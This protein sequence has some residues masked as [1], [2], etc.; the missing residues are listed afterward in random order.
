M[1]KIIHYL[2]QSIRP[3]VAL[4]VL[5]ILLV[6]GN[7][8]AQDTASLSPAF[9]NIAKPQSTKGWIY[10]WENYKA[11]PLTLFDDL[12][13]AFELSKEDKMA[14][15]K[16]VK[17]EIGFTHYR[18]QQYYKSIPVLFGEYMVH[19]QSDGFVNTANGRLITG[20]TLGNMATI[21]EKQALA[22]AL[23]FMGAHKYLWQNPEMENDLKRQKKSE[24][25]SYFP[26]GELVFAPNN[27]NETYNAADYRLC[28]H[29][30]IYTDGGDVKPKSVY[31]DVLTGKVIYYTDL[32]MECSSATGTSAFNGSVSF[33]TEFSGSTYRSHDNCQ[34]TDFYVYNCNRGG[35]T[36][37]F[38]T[39]ADNSW[40]NQ[41][42]VQAQWGVNR[43][44]NYY[45][46]VHS[47]TSWDNSA[48]D[49]IAYNN[50]VYGSPPTANNAC[51]G[52]TGNSAIFGAGTTTAATDDW[53]TDDLIGHEFTHGVTQSSANLVYNKESGA[54]NE[55]FSDIFG[56]MV[57]SYSE[58]NCDYLVG[59]DRGAI[60]SFINPKSFGD[61]DTYLGTNWVSTS[62]CTPLNSNDNCG[63]H[64][65]SSVQNRWFYLLS[66]GGNGTNDLGKSYNVAGISRFKARQIA[67]RALVV[68]LNSSSKYIDSRKATLQAAWDLYGQCSA[69]II[70][71][72]DAW[73]AVGVESQ[74]PAYTFNVC[75]TYPAS[76]TLVQAISKLTASSSGCATEI[77]PSTSTVYFTARDQVILYP[78]F[79]ANAGSNFVAYLEPCSSTRW[80]MGDAE[81]PMGELEKGLK[82]PVAITGNTALPTARAAA[83]TSQNMD[84]A[85]VSVSPNPFTSG[86]NISINSKQDTK[87]Q[88]IIYSAVGVKVK[89]Q[90]SVTLSKGL[91][92]IRFNAADLSQGVYML[93][94]RMDNLKTV[95]KI[96]KL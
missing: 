29:F 66:E 46:A 72:G 57:E 25:A 65:N 80:R 69:E 11:N 94:V 8:V 54:L 26:K 78:G 96:V 31:V 75:G 23:Q 7:A 4:L 60:R 49:L 55:S 83:T 84:A 19:Q 24:N 91:N 50:A 18:Y 58:G 47:R 67:Y 16:T 52:C 63:V 61:P 10:F 42:A 86:F 40:T 28:W 27:F 39:D 68:Y 71:V 95:K 13:V 81:G 62:G 90:T 14:L 36:N 44:Y 5:F 34:S 88:I 70:A 30:K 15:I 74:S 17:D 32:A 12:Q 53:N 64:T 59:A 51:W 79:K 76:G 56:E 37:T 1:K 43:F 2:T 38:Y 45:L 87:A 3:P 9:K 22:A 77:T 35:A 6:V 41:S 82:N 92:N 21:A 20:L 89:E 73:H 33:K 85:G 48:G 93:E